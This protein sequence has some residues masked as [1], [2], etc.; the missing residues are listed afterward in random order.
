MHSFKTHF[1]RHLLVASMDQQHMSLT[2]LK[3]EQPA[4]TQA[5]F[6]SLSDVHKRLDGIQMAPFSLDVETP[7]DLSHDWL[8]NF[9]MDLAALCDIWRCKWYQ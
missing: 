6:S 3:V 9:A 4:F 5:S 7:T 1:H 8:M 2:L